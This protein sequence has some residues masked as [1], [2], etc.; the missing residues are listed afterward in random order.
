[1]RA[2]GDLYPRIFER[3]LGRRCEPVQESGGET[4]GVDAA[5]RWSSFR[6]NECW[7]GGGGGGGEG[8]KCCTD[9]GIYDVYRM[10]RYSDRTL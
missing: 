6:V 3:V 9:D 5:Q 4:N 2:C 10:L 1:M 7:G 8:G